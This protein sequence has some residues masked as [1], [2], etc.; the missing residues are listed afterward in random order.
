MKVLLVNKFY[1]RR[2]GDCTAVFSTEQLLRS[3]GHEVAIFSIKHP[4]NEFSAWEEYFAGEVRFTSTTIPEKLAAAVRIFHSGEVARKFN[5]LLSDFKPD[6][7]H[8]HNIHSYIS[9]LVAKIAHG[10]GIRV[11]WTLHDYKVVC[12]TYS[13]LRNGEIC[14][15]CF[16]DI[17]KVFRYKCMKGRRTDSLFAWLEACYWN[18]RK[19]SDITDLFISPSYFLKS[20]IIEGGFASGQIEVLH[21]FLPKKLPLSTEKEDYYCYVGRLSVEK[22]VDTLLEAAGQVTYPLKIIGG[23]PLLDLYRT[24]YPH[25]QIEFLG[26]VQPDKLYPII[27]KAR[28]LVIPSVWYENNPFSAIESLCLGT[29]VLGARIGGI[30]ELIEEGKNGFLF[31]SGNTAE[32]RD[33]IYDCFSYFTDTY[34]FKETAEEAQNKFGPESFYNKLMKI[35]DH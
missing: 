20:K 31:R 13:C 27:Q 15:E 4:Q 34:D 3:K 21:N 26:H 9:P 35:Y 22:G 28:F 32:L 19:L 6:I 14:E 7:V 30:P 33:K 1:Y 18:R 5:R 12:P 2:G 16:R 10:K 23:G 29:P 24:K 25:R 11:V 17:S 8:L